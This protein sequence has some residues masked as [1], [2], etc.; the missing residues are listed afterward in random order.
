M[1]P[2]F[3]TNKNLLT[4]WF[5][6]DTNFIHKKCTLKPGTK[7]II[8]IDS[9]AKK[10]KNGLFSHSDPTDTNSELIIGT[11][12]SIIKYNSCYSNK[13]GKILKD[14][15]NIKLDN[16]HNFWMRGIITDEVNIN[17]N[18]KKFKQ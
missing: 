4:D 17:S 12:V 10:K 5:I 14:G 2:G 18:F 9:M 16:P 6:K 15:I 1:S 7:I 13:N 8:G 11:I 3:E